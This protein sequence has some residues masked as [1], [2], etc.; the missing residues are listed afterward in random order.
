MKAGL[1]AENMR[2][3]EEKAELEAKT[4]KLEAEKADYV[5]NMKKAMDVVLTEKEQLKTQIKT[6]APRKQYL[7][8][9]LGE[10]TLD[11]ATLL[12]VMDAIQEPIADIL[13]EIEWCVAMVGN[14][15]KGQQAQQPEQPQLPAAPGQG[16]AKEMLAHPAGDND[17]NFSS[18][19]QVSEVTEHAVAP[20]PSTSLG[21]KRSNG[22]DGNG[23]GAVANKRLKTVE[24]DKL[25]PIP[26]PLNVLTSIS[27]ADLGPLLDLTGKVVP[28]MLWSQIRDM[29]PIPRAFEWPEGSCQMWILRCPFHLDR[30]PCAMSN[31]T[32]WY[33][34]APTGTA[35]FGVNHIC[36]DHQYPHFDTKT[37]VEK[38]GTRS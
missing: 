2:L 25:L 34:I 21:V 27:L 19:P 18:E 7:E 23:G 20:G 28:Q 26:K 3:K 8:R 35:G 31:Y 6:D 16:L 9:Q 32:G 12:N 24:A 17:A 22:D 14:S 11:R 13:D 36:G 5:L 4:T 15:G 30:K 33:D 37:L 1:E 38:H 29:R 10:T